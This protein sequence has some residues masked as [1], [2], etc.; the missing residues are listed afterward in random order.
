MRRVN[1]YTAQPEY[2]PSDPA[3]Y[4]NGLTRLGPSIG[5]SKLGGSIYELPAGQSIC[6]YH[7]EHG[8]EEWLIVLSGQP[9]IRHPAGEEQLKPGDTVCFPVGP[10]GAH[11]VT[12]KTRETVRVLMLSTMN[13]PAVAVYPDSEKI[14]VFTEGGMD[15]AIFRRGERVEYYDGEKLARSSRRPRAS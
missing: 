10:E 13:L 12:N 11:K 14:G 2:D 3:G 4:G 8:D 5:A 9:T 1:L 15:D 7:Y 6:P